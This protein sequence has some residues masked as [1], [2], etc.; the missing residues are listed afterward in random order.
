MTSNKFIAVFIGKM[1]GDF[2]RQLQKYNL[3]NINYLAIDFDQ[4]KNFNADINIIRISPDSKPEDYTQQ[5][6]NY[7][8]GNSILF[9]FTSTENLCEML[10]GLTVST[11]ARKMGI[12]NIAA[13]LSYMAYDDEESAE[14]VK[15]FKSITDAFILLSY[16]ESEEGDYNGLFYEGLCDRICRGVQGI[17]Y[18]F[19]KPGLMP[20]KFNKL[21]NFLSE[22]GAVEFSTSQG[23]GVKSIA[24]TTLRAIDSIRGYEYKKVSINIIPALEYFYDAGAILRYSFSEAARVLIIIATGKNFTLKNLYRAVQIVKSRANPKKCN[25]ALKILWSHVF[26]ETL[27]DSEVRV[28]LISSFGFEAPSGIYYET[29]EYMFRNESPDKICNFFKKDLISIN[30]KDKAFGIR[31][32]EAVVRYGTA[33]LLN[34]CFDRGLDYD[35]GGIKNFVD[36]NDI[37]LVTPFES[38]ESAI[39]YNNLDT[40]KVLLEH[41]IIYDKHSG[42]TA[43][44][45]AAHQEKFYIAKYLI[46]HGF[47]L[48]AR[49]NDGRTALI[50]AAGRVNLKITREL[51]RA[52]ADVNIQDDEGNTALTAI[53]ANYWRKDNESASKKGLEIA[54]LLINNGADVNI[55]NLKGENALICL[56]ESFLYNKNVNGEIINFLVDSGININ[57]VSNNGD[58]ALSLAIENHLPVVTVLLSAGAD[59]KTLTL[60]DSTLF[61]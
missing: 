22:I 60:R 15:K 61:I 49:D 24:L 2:F 39:E 16:S 20:I 57:H 35:S 12:L 36:D 42:R 40:L 38:L 47:N 23:E 7:L 45:I 18:L 5:L 52:G 10:L 51:V 21:K 41:G 50:W 44:I 33:E 56:L 46:D 31:F 30:D 34:F 13:V 8:A 32:I 27:K 26:D 9:L 3:E 55:L 53:G 29:Y 28:T 59:F 1:G 37:R 58:S 19:T 17:N 11:L 54:K 25:S 6:T 4:E 14:K 48:N 43:L